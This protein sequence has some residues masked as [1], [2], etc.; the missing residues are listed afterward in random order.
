MRIRTDSKFA[1]REELEATHEQ[2]HEDRHALAREN[3][4]LRAS[5]EQLQERIERAERYR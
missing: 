2:Q 3:H 4:E 5:Q 1:H